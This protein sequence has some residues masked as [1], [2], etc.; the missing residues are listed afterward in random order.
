MKRKRPQ[1]EESHSDTLLTD[2]TFESLQLS[3]ETL[4]ALEEMNFK[5]M[6]EVQARCLPHA[7]GGRDVL[8]AARTGSGK[9]LAF[10]IPII[11]LLSKVKWPNKMGTAA[12]VIAPTRELVIQTHN[13]LS[14]LCSHHPHSHCVVMG[15]ANRKV[16]VEKLSKGTT[17][18][19]ATPGRLLDHLQNTKGF[20]FKNL[21]ILV[22]DEAD[23]CLDIGFEEEMHEILRILPKERQ[24]LLFSATQTTRVEDLIKVS[25]KNR[26]IY[27][28]V[29]DKRKTATVSGLDQGYLICSG[30]VRFQ[31]LFTFLKKNMKKKI[32]VFF[33]SCN[34]VKFYAELFNFIDVPVLEL[35]GKQKQQKRTST[36]FEFC[37]AQNAILLCTDVA[38]RGLD[39]PAV[40]WIVQYDP[41]D[42]PKE[43][44][45]RVGRT[46]R[47]VDGKGHVVTVVPSRALLFLLPSEKGFLYYLKEAKVPLHEY[48][49]AS[50]KLANIQSQLESLVERNYYLHKSA[51]EAYRSY[52]LA[53]ASHHMKHIFNMEALDLK[54]V[55]KSFGLTVPP[56]VH[57]QSQSTLNSI[58]KRQKS[59]RVGKPDRL[60]A[61]LAQQLGSSL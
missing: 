5:Y 23:R 1:T 39:I 18:I 45:H 28:G 14:E 15:G 26:P 40:D 8:G 50:S 36:F 42:E 44:I 30:E 9:T 52:L 6:T 29:D 20:L 51:K 27:V 2:E 57:V 56:A 48:E 43:Y 47:G 4:A 22:I 53:Y 3:K 55:A 24:T 11:E 38:A 19:V 58:K 7:L 32:I 41:P 37:K 60:K 61:L 25:F 33:S 16:E 49:I 31:T 21:Q 34:V 13:V 17:I 10:L 59:Q 35:H 46:A 54:A 12:V